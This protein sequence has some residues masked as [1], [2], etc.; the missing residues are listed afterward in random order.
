QQAQVVAVR[1]E[2]PVQRPR[3]FTPGP[4]DQSAEVGA[5]GGHGCVRGARRGANGPP[6]TTDATRADY[7]RGKTPM[8]GNSAGSGR[9]FGRRGPRPVKNGWRKGLAAKRL[10]R[11]GII[12]A[13]RAFVSSGWSRLVE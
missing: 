9:I 3:L 4:L 8:Q 5:A 13:N 12:L 10:R 1:V 2:Q 7:A 11:S 6:K